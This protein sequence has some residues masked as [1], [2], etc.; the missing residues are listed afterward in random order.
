[1]VVHVKDGVHDSN[2]VNVEEGEAVGE[3]VPVAATVVVS[4]EV[5]VTV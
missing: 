5:V 1:M 3:E 2:R 4:V